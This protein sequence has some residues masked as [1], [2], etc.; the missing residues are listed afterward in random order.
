MMNLYN[1]LNVRSVTT[2]K[3][4]WLKKIAFLFFAMF[5][6]L[7]A[8]AQ[9]ATNGGS[10][11]AGTYPS[12]AAAVTALNG[13]TI[14]SP[15]VITLTGNETAPNG[16]GYYITATGTS[17]NTIT[18]QGSSSTISAGVN[19]VAGNMDAVFKIVGGDYI[20]IQNFT[21]QENA[22]NTVVATGATNTMTEAGVLLIH[23]SVTDGAQN[24]TIQNN[25]ISLS[26]AYPN[27]V[28]ILST[29]A[30]TTTN[31]S[32]GAN[33]TADATSTAGTN[34]NNKIYGNTISGV[35]F[36]IYFICPPVTATIT[37]AGND[38]GGS[39]ITTANIITYGNN[40]TSSNPW[41]RA[42]AASAGVQIRNGAGVNISYN[43]I[44]TIGTLTIAST[45]IR[46]SSGTTPAGV[47]Y[48]AT[49]SNNTITMTNVGTTDITGIDF[50]HGISTATI[51]GNSNII[52]INQNATAANSGVV[53]A[54]KANYATA[55]NTA[56]SNT[57]VINQSETT[58]ALS[59]AVTGI[60][61]AG[62][63]TTITANSNSVTFNQTGP[64]TGT[65]SAAVIGV[66]VSGAATTGN[67]LSNTVIFNQTTA[68]ASGI[69]TALTGI[70][71]NTGIT[72]LN[73]GGLGNGNTITVK[74]AVSGAGTYGSGAINYINCSAAHGT[75]TV[76]YN[77]L[78]TTGST[79][80]STGALIGVFQDA[81][82][83]VHVI[84]TE[85]AFNVDR[86][87]AS[88]SIIFQST[89]GTP[90]EVKDTLTNNTITMTGLA[91][92][93]T[94]TGISSLGGPTTTFVNSKAIDGNTINISGT[95]TGT[96][97][98]ITA[99][100][101]NTSF[102]RNNNITIN[103]AAATVTGLTLSSTGNTIPTISGNTLSLTSSSTAPTAMTGIS[104]AATGA[105][106]ITNNTFSALNFTGVFTAAG[107][108]TGIAISAGTAANVFNN[109]ITN[110][111]SGAAT[112][113]GSAVIDGI[114]VSGGT[115]V[116]VYKN[117]IY[118]LSTQ[119]V[120]TSTVVSGIRISGGTTN[121]VYNN[122]IGGLTAPAAAS[123]D[124]LRG[125]NITSTSSSTTQNIYYNTIYLN[126]TSTGANFGSTGIFHTTSTTA[127]TSAL[128]LRNNII[129]NN[130][131]PAGTG[132]TVAFRRSSGAASNLA[133]YAATSNNNLF[134]AGTPGASNLIY[135]DGT[136]SAQ[137][138]AAYKGGAFTAGTIAPRD[139]ASVSESPTFVSTAGANS[140]FL[141][142]NTA[143]PT[144]IESG[145]ANIAAVTDD[146]DGD[147]RN[148]TTPDMGADEFAGTGADFSGPVISYTALGNILG[149]TN[150]TLTATITDISG[151]PTAG[152]GLPVLYYNINGGAYT[153]VQGVSIGSN[154]YTFTF[155]AA[156]TNHNDIVRYYVV[157]QDNAG[158]PNVSVSPAAGAA[159][160]TANPPTA[161]T[162]PTTPSQYSVFTAISGT[163]TVCATGCDY[164]S[165]TNAGGIF[166]DI[167]VRPV[168]GNI[169]IEIAG[170]LTA[171]TGANA[172]NA[173]ASPFTVKMYPTGVARIVSGSLSSNA[174]VKLNGADRVT[175][176]GSIGGTGT[177][178][179]LTVN[180]TSTTSPTAIA[181]VSLGT[182]LGATDNTIKNLNII[183]GSATATSYGISV[184]G[185][186]GSAGADND[187]T[188]LINNNISVVTKGIYAVGTAAGLN[189]NLVITSNTVTST[190]TG[191]N[192][193]IQIGQATGALLNKNTLSIE[194]STASQPVGISVEA[195]V[196]DSSVDSNII[197]KVLAT[198]TGGY[199]GRGITIGTGTPTSNVTVSNNVISG[200]NGSNFSTFDN[201]SSMGIGV[202][203]VGSGSILDATGG[204]KL[205]FNSVNMAGSYV[206]ANACLT[207]A[208]YVGSAATNLDIRDNVFVNT[209]NNTN[210]GTGVGSKNYS[211]YSAAASAAFATMNYN[212]YYVS[213]TQ[214]VLA[215]IGSDRSNL[216]AVVTGFGG[217]ANSINVDPT[218]NSATN[219]QPTT[220]ALAGLG[221]IISGITTD[222]LNVTRNN[223]P[224]IGAYEN[225]LDLAGPVITYM[226][227][228]NN[229]LTGARTLSVTVTDAGSGVPTSGTGLP[230]VYWRINAG[231]YTAATGTFVSGNQYDFSIG[232]GSNIGDTVS[233]Y[234]VAQDN[235]ANVS[236]SPSVGAGTFTASPPVAG[237]P[238]TTP[239]SYTN[240]ATLSG[241]Y[242][243]GTGQ[244]YTTLTA[245]VTAY[246]SACLA[247][248]ITFVLTDATYG[249]S[250]TFPIAI[251]E[252][253]SASAVNTLTIKPATTATITGA[254][255]SNG[256]VRLNGADYVTIDGSNSGG[257]DRSLTITNTST[258]APTAVQLVSSSTG[259][260]HN[261]VK[262]VNISTAVSTTTG[263]A[264]SVGGGTGGNNGANND[265]TTIQN[266]NI[267][268]ATV[269]IY[270]VG[271][272]AGVMDNLVV[273]NNI[274]DSN[275]SLANY[276]MQLGNANNAIISGNTVSVQSSVAGSPVGISLET[277]FLSSV[278]SSNKITK[279]FTTATG[280]W[281]GRGITI[282]TGSA[283]SNVTIANNTIAGV[284]G[285][286]HTAFGN[287]S[288]I[289]IGVGVVGNSTTLS[290]TTGGVN[291]YY[292]S[293]NLTGSYSRAVNSLTA[294]L[295]VGSGATALDIRDNIFANTMNN[296]NGSG[297]GSKQYAVYSAAA[298]G[299][300][301]TMD[302]ND[303]YV[304]ATQGV[305]GFIGSDRTTLAAMQTGFGQNVNSLTILPSFTSV[306]D[307]HLLTGSNVQLDNFGTPISGITLDIDGDTRS[308]TPDMGADEFT[309][310]VCSSANGGSAAAV[311]AT[312]CT[313]GSTTINATGYSNGSGTT[314]EWE[315]SADMAFTT[316]ISMGAAN[317][318]YAPLATGTLNTTTY[319]RLKVICSAGVPSYSTVAGVTIY[320]PAALAV[321]PNVAICAGGN[322]IL[323]VSGAV[324]YTWSPAAGLS[325][326]TG[327]SVTANP[328]STTTYS[329][330]G[331]DSNGCST[332]PATVIV[333]VNP[334]PASLS[335]IETPGGSICAGS[336]VTLTANTGSGS[337][338]T[339]VASGA[340][341]LAIPDW[342]SVGVAQNLIVSGIPANASITK[343]EVLLNIT[344]LFDGDVEVNLEAPNGK[345][346]NLLADRG[347][348]DDNFTNTVITSLTTAPALSTGTAPFTGTF[349]ADLSAS[350]ALMATVN[351]QVFADL[352]TVANG[353]WKVRA[354]DDEE[355]VSG[356]LVDCT[357]RVYYAVTAPDVT[358]TATTGTIYSDA[359]A[360]T[361]YVANTP[362][363]IV[364]VKPTSPVTVTATAAYGTCGITSDI[365]L[366]PLPLPE[367]TVDPITICKGGSGAT[368]TAVGSGNAYAWAPATGLSA[369]S[370]SSVTA[371][372]TVTTTYTVTATNNTTGCQNQHTVMV[373]VNEPV[374][375]NSITPLNPSAI[376]GQQVVFTV[377]ATGTGLTYQWYES[378]D[379][380]AW[381]T[382]TG[383]TGST[384]TVTAD[385]DANNGYQY[386]VIVSGAAPCASATSAA[387]TLTIDTTGIEEQPVNSTVCAPGQATFTV[388]ASSDD[389]EA[390]ITYGWEVSTDDGSS[391]IPV[392]DGADNTIA[393]YTFSGS[394]AATLVLENTTIA[395]SGWIFHAVVNGYIFSSDAELTINNPVVITTP[396]IADQT[397]CGTGG[398]AVFTVA[399]TGDS[400]SYQW[401]VSTDGGSSW[402]NVVN[403][404]GVSGATST[405]LNVTYP[406]SGANGYQ[407]QAIVSGTAACASVPSDVALLTIYSPAIT[408]NPVNATVFVPTAATFTVA[409]SAPAPTYQWVYSTTAG[410]SYANVIDGTPA[411]VIYSGATTATLTVTP[412]G[413][414]PAGNGYFY[415][416]TVTDAG[417]TSTSTAAQLTVNDYCKTALTTTG[418]VNRGI[419][420]VVISDVTATTSV[421]NASTVAAPW[422]Y[423]YP[424]PVLSINQGHNASVAITLST[425]GAAA[426]HS[427][428]WVDYNANGTFETG[429]N[430]ALS[431][432]STTSSTG[433]VVVTYNFQVPF[434]ASVGQTRIRIRA[435]FG[436]AY[437]AAGA[438]TATA[439]GETEDYILDILPSLPCS[440]TP[441]AA[442][443][444]ASSTTFCLSG[445]A[446]LT[447]TGYTT[448]ETG[449]SL[450]W[451]N[452]AGIIGGATSA[453]YITP[454]LTGNET[455]YVR[456]ICANGG[457]FTDSAPVTIT[458][459]NPQVLT[460][461]PGT[462]CGPGTVTLSA[463]AATG[464]LDW[465]A[466]ASGGSALATGTSFMTPVIN[467][468]T[469][470]YVENVLG[471]SSANLGPVSP[472]VGTYGTSFTGSYEIFTVTTPVTLNAVSAFPTAAG[473]VTIELMNSSGT[474]LQTSATYTVTAAQATTTLSTVGAPV[475]IPV[476]FNI[477]AGTGYRLNFKAGSTATLVRNDGGATATY[478]PVSGVTI[479]GNSNA[480][481]GYYYNF[482][483]WSLTTGCRSART[484]VVATI[485]APP[486]LTLS[487]S[488]TTICAGTPS[489]IVTLTTPVANFD[490]Y[491]WSPLTGVSGTA[492]TG[493]TFNPSA[494]TTYTLTATNTSSG[495]V[496]SASIT[497]TV[498]P[499]PSPIV[500]TPSSSVIC[501]GSIVTLN[502]SGGQ[503]AASYCTPVVVGNPGATADY[504]NNFSFGSITNN[505]NGDA[506][507]DYTYYSAL[508]ANVVANGTTT[509]PISLQAGG[510]SSLYAQQFRIWI[511]FNQNGTFE[512]S[513]SVFA[514][515]TATF[516]TTTVTGTATIPTTAYN[517]MTRMRVASRYSVVVDNTQSCQ[518]GTTTTGSYGEFEDYNVTIT[519]GVNPP[520]VWTP[521]AGLYT[522]ASATVAYTGTP[523]GTVYAKPTG[524]TT[525]TATAT[526]S[527]TGCSASGT[528]IITVN[529]TPT[530]TAPSTMDLCAGSLTSPVALVGTPSGVV[531]DITG[532]A[533]VGLANQIGVTSIPA[534]T[535]ITG[536]ATITVTPRANGCTGLAVTFLIKV[537][538]QTVGGSV[539]GGTTICAGSTSAL[540]TLSGH[541]G[542]VVRWESSVA[543]FAVW[544]PIA[545]TSTTYTSGV[546]TQTT[547]FRAVVQSGT[548]QEVASAAT[549]VTVNA[550]T[551][552][553]V[554][555]S[556]A[557]LNTLSVIS[558]NGMASNSTSTVAYTKSG[559]P[560]TPV[561][562]TA[563]ASGVGSF[564]VM[565]TGAGQTVVITSITR[566]DVTPNCPFTPISGNSAT[567]VV[568]TQCS[569]VQ[570]CG[571]TLA[572]IDTSITANL[573]ANVQ[574]YRW[575]VTTL[576]GLTTGMI[577]TIDTQLR[578]M[579]LTNLANYAFATQ[580][581]VEVASLR[582]GVW[583][584]FSS[585]CTVI[586]PSVTTSLSNCNQTLTSLSDPVYA[587]IVPFVGGYRFRITDPVNATNTQILDRPIRDFKMT[588]ITNFTVQYGK[589][590]NVEV[591][592][593]NTDGTYMPYGSV[594]QLHTPVFPTTSLQ[595]SQ[596]EDYMVPN[597]STQIY[598]FSYPG[599][600]GY[601]FLLTGPGLPPAGAEVVKS[602][603][604][605]ALA[606]FA[607][608]GLIPGATYNVKVR[609]IFNLSDPAG[610]YGKTCTIV[611]P[612]AARQIESGK[613][614]FNAV[615][616]PNPFAENFNIDVTTSINE[617]I[618]VKVYDMTGRLLE[619]REVKVSEIESL[620]VGDRYP[621]GVYNVIVTQG[622]NVKTL[623]VIKR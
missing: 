354:Y 539:A 251:G 300:F 214:G 248:P 194:T 325:A 270:A 451:Y 588:M 118:G 385:V 424:T 115:S 58:G 495:C 557:C 445:S 227:L 566:T 250:E 88:G 577:Q 212:D 145:G 148:A 382:L 494:T 427:A 24:N 191:A 497:V 66:N 439:N 505:A 198:N 131:T 551:L 226:A 136:S 446:T 18:I 156:A 204:V 263:Y 221:T 418:N 576:T 184:G 315:R 282:A 455:Y 532:G 466:A 421:S 524:T 372:P 558:L 22:A 265:D 211:V 73:I 329:V 220:T 138:I 437:T 567:P 611:T 414:T 309:T 69:T 2:F 510:T 93:T 493:Y 96:T 398:T 578:T 330:V 78:N 205:Y 423:L 154:Q 246:N 51:V 249:A 533:A 236:A 121:T 60:T 458:V 56:N 522:D 531:F 296:T 422:Y 208:L 430:V 158:T 358:W 159:G 15:V 43:T 21:I 476:G 463:T 568:S 376:D 281:A 384:L 217:N 49:A 199:G 55:T 108:T 168:S 447:A 333:T 525:Y 512:A 523:T 27:A 530:A 183:T 407:Y 150:Q 165:L 106:S 584:P 244:T 594:C 593:K 581:N 526:I 489:A 279:A 352:F 306:T 412:S 146:F 133:N 164:T 261:T 441:T 74:Q 614:Q 454:T 84:V 44:N 177:D 65:I 8:N 128:N 179:S 312:F 543:P 10:G 400:L 507:S 359:S 319:Y 20:T 368:L 195:G 509:Y 564:S 98:G 518:I 259:A 370:G 224:S 485:S 80:R 41:N 356:N 416:A 612:G 601:A 472:A 46:I 313:S 203:V 428:I 272:G 71:A 298:I 196:V 112:S 345:I 230:V 83:T 202:G 371:N 375:I 393:G 600:I 388:V 565:V 5:T 364:Y 172:L 228:A 553:S 464:T 142:V 243:V 450:Q 520:V 397:L 233:Y 478:G 613:V 137:T 514:T 122:L 102:Y 545:N 417:C 344:H 283:T 134:Y 473:T 120:G 342:S 101:G 508:N 395:S 97:I 498:N 294:A 166:A 406:A 61:L 109:V 11:L 622:D 360:T 480:T 301:T 302:F 350:A 213:G 76:A 155:G 242:N 592:L 420:N 188:S 19:T 111:S 444:N 9:V 255:A 201:S 392:S 178:R 483:N 48:T 40:T 351:T 440:G 264:I 481:T 304:A 409:T 443:V 38:I 602:V 37:E 85:N 465:F 67:V 129:V 620:Q 28:G 92:T 59:G 346:V 275:S 299:A 429:E 147:A 95:N 529:P 492:A 490:S 383:E 316:P 487:T 7:G 254:L 517:G 42:V 586:T 363:T 239:S 232:A 449:I 534:F 1:S 339:P 17:T 399:A 579:K 276:G 162:P 619:T 45:A 278:V 603:R 616:F 107:T 555:A 605:F 355:F 50:G 89:S 506:V 419:S 170:D 502:S 181:L 132:L 62:S 303:Y 367:F 193:G 471:G 401:K 572:T 260:M 527:G 347:S 113:A 389:P 209:M 26:S 293:I 16:T 580:Y 126:G 139:T 357:L 285:D 34:S 467:G 369:T 336:I 469:T 190:S 206:R 12:L 349:K 413:P 404:S 52:T 328:A 151:V 30:S 335:I 23:G 229:C 100:Y 386:Q 607:G 176:D 53:T 75:V 225:P 390:E 331:V 337:G 362:A 537:S 559:V 597:N 321:S 550:V 499:V 81:T 326:T 223:P 549:T 314:Y 143:T 266:S 563:N 348:S 116:N 308:A 338:M 267:S 91:G 192:F 570:S 460:T 540:L 153:A 410:G 130:S 408:S 127:S 197:T 288:A 475:I 277:G 4:T 175:I 47:T 341:N 353:T 125:I 36:G 452:S 287:S 284:G 334:Y 187:N 434:T 583:G 623:R 13:A 292:N 396:V 456:V 554:T 536:V 575:R 140:Q 297:T 268:G 595:D 240:L 238:P 290:N 104:S 513:E 141:H 528:A 374:V 218:F 436:S 457:L 496:N 318:V 521:T 241:P 415:K 582:N 591:A 144:Q 123:V 519:G 474:V 180:N 618:N 488:T 117:K 617:N 253:A 114:L 470:Y 94:A 289:G 169:N 157:A 231:A 87:A 547:Q 462:H 610:P 234:V 394:D 477:P 317:A 135:S 32:P 273:S 432:A 379:G 556:D 468:T 585:G 323:T 324:T 182:A 343:V 149:G 403:G 305:L 39:S 608:A 598:A 68:V 461:T 35:A 573:V 327:A 237:T 274:I 621:S 72:T 548:C 210:T 310:V 262:N 491:V 402:T 271:T 615:A 119:T 332:A 569:Q 438:C 542:N 256:L 426:H 160:L 235:S 258:T 574:G 500:V 64:G 365:T 29:S 189:N 378:P 411:G 257:T 544:T 442:T 571:I 373:T 606:D 269:G 387:A 486:A 562:V 433:G 448:T 77:N 484:A 105:G 380:S 560:Q 3:S 482:Y 54:I 431:T 163:K 86:V 33:T 587:N 503:V 391:F 79:V 82:V 173:F 405:T 174:L 222:I 25:T 546:L 377:S 252:N 515:S 609:L 516:N 219:L 320:T 280:G 361:S 596:C 161:A 590:Y 322:T 6:V 63:S 504:L 459:N 14:T 311:T 479:T 538:P 70:A 599:A 247:G 425:N 535:A 340:V 604:T 366:S 186:A 171:E 103:N 541:T 31:A 57:I 561:S 167:N 453:T 435:G 501:P 124:A 291:I 185:T 90:S 215:F 295:Y 245:A 152:V 511:D 589:T 381:N 99:Q 110:I 207:A 216:A 552:S 307:L 286:N 200:V